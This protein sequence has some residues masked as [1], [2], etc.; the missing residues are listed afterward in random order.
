MSAREVHVTLINK[1]HSTL[2]LNKKS[3]AHGEW[4]ENPPSTIHPGEIVTWRTDS[5]GFLTGTEGRAY[6]KDGDENTI[7]LWWDNPYIG[8][9]SNSIYF[10]GNESSANN[11]TYYGGY[12]T[13]RGNNEYVTF[14][15]CEFLPNWMEK[16]WYNSDKNYKNT[17]LFDIIIPG[18]NDSGTYAIDS[19]SPMSPDAPE[20]LT[21]LNDIDASLVA[22]W[23][24][25][26]NF[27]INKQLN[28]GIR[29]FDLRVAQN[30]HSELYIVHGKYSIPVVSLLDAV[31][32]FSDKN[33]YEIIILDFNHFYQMDSSSHDYLANLINQKIGNRLFPLS[34]RN[35]ITPQI[36]WNNNKTIIIT[37]AKDE[38]QANNFFEKNP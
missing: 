34:M 38:S 29:Y 27:D 25:T 3:L 24:K 32:S 13:E 5:A 28:A 15:V 17:I 23:A 11:Y 30:N 8:S 33:P 31:A 4:I 21:L 26:Q 37:Y 18:T 22:R 2:N 10:N 16:F 20:I 14:T 1:T 19:S 6:Y 35:S 9:D 36:M 7:E 12:Q